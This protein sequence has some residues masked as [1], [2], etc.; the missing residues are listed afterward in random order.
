MDWHV[1]VLWYVL[2]LYKDVLKNDEELIKK[3]E[4]EFINNEILNKYNNLFFEVQNQNKQINQHKP[5]KQTKW[6][7]KQKSPALFLG[8]H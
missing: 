4:Y 7:I 3:N 1:T 5:I 6:N 8:K 2:D